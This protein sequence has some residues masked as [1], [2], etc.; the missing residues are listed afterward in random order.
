MDQLYHYL[1]EGYDKAEALLRA[2]LDFPEQAIGAVQLPAY[3]GGWMLVGD[4]EPL[5]AA[6]GR[7][8]W[9][10]IISLLLIG[11]GVWVGKRIVDELND[12]N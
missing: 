7:S 11:G 2:K 6:T 4:T 8:Y 10:A 5:V 9:V 3:W 1:A 12:Q